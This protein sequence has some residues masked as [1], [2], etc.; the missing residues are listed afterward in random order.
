MTR[1]VRLYPR[2]WRDRYEAELADLLEQRPPSPGDRIDLVRG[3]L[4]A[5]L[6]PQAG[7][8]PM[9]WTH[10]LPGV[11]SLATGLLWA[12]AAVVGSSI[13]GAASGAFVGLALLMMLISLPGDYLA[14]HALRTA[15]GIGVLG[16]SVVL[17]NLSP[18]PMAAFIYFAAAVVFLAGTLTLA[19]IRADIGSTVRWRLV[20]G[21]VV[22]PAFALI[23]LLVTRVVPEHA[24]S[25]VAALGVPYGLAWA[26]IGVRMTV[27]GSPTL[28]DPVPAVEARRSVGMEIPG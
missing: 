1:F 8:A 5:H 20:W 19:A 22:L 9:P 11:A 7:T 4:D 2:H 21:A 10:R 14:R 13:D 26:L 12:A 18:W 27:R 24:T 25:P 16:I 23:V 3:A 15:M 6:H 17:F 28:V